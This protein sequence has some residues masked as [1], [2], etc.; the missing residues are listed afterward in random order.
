MKI[1]SRLWNLGTF[2]IECLISYISIICLAVVLVLVLKD[3]LRTYFKSLSWSLGVRSFSLGGQ[4]QEVLVLVLVLGGQVLVLILVLGGQVLVLVLGDQVL[5]NIPAIDMRR[6]YIRVEPKN[7][8]MLSSSVK[9]LRMRTHNQLNCFSKVTTVIAST[10]ILLIGLKRITSG[11]KRYMKPLN[12][13]VIS[14]LILKINSVQAVCE[15]KNSKK[16]KLTF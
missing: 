11:I 13:K 10:T 12:R 5:V 7:E 1:M 3:Y 16:L 9:L 4:V 15:Q 6:A 8:E 2:T 14:L